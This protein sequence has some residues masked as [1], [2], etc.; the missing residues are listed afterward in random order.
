LR[1]TAQDQW[2]D[3]NAFSGFE[4]RWIKLFLGYNSQTKTT[5][6]GVDMAL[7][8]DVKVKKS[9]LEAIESFLDK[10]I[11]QAVVVEYTA[12]KDGDYTSKLSVVEDGVK[13]FVDNGF[14]E[15]GLKSYVKYAKTGGAKHGY[16]LFETTRAN[17]ALAAIRQD[18]ANIETD[19]ANKLAR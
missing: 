5:H 2:R 14:E 19:L 9:V 18:L 12:K 7:G 6:K 16:V 10:G 17:G 8:L 15:N 3:F 13:Y 4:F 11:N 1:A